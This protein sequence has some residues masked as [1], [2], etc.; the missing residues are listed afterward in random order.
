M[1]RV[2][3]T[4]LMDS[5]LRIEAHGIKNDDRA[6]RNHHKWKVLP[7]YTEVDEVIRVLICSE[8]EYESWSHT[9]FCPA[10]RFLGVSELG[11]ACPSLFY[12]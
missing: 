12:W 10:C 2:G 9:V 1:K 8:G 6:M 11:I 3:W 4:A 5:L 7:L